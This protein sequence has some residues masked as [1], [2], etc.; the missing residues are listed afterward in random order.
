MPSGWCR[1]ILFL[2]AGG[3]A[4]AAN[5]GARLLFNNVFSYGAYYELVTVCPVD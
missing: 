5:I 1:F 3:S 2:V 4:G